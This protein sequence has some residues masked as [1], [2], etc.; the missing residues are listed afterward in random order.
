MSHLVRIILVILCVLLILPSGGTARAQETAD[1]IVTTI[2]FQPFQHGYML[3]REDEDKITVV[4]AD[5]ATKTGAPCQEVYRDTWD[6]REYTIPAPPPGLLV[7]VRGF[8]WLYKADLQLARR[9]GYATAEETGRTAEVRTSSADG[10]LVT[11]VTP[12]EPLPG[13]PASLRLAG[14]DEPGLTYCFPRRSENRDAINTWVARQLF[15]HG[16]MVWR[17]DMPDRVEIW[18]YDTQLAP[19]ISCGDT[20]ADTWKPG[21]YLTYGELA[22][23]GKRLPSRGFGNAWLEHEYIRRSLGYPVSDEQGGFAEL[24]Y[25]PFQHPTRGHLL[26]RNMTA[27]LADGQAWTSRVTI[28]N[29]ATP[30]SDRILSTACERILIPHQARWAPPFRHPARG[31]RLTVPEAKVEG[32]ARWSPAAAAS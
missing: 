3:W 8:G 4:Y 23:P 11:E 20:L 31:R 32:A 25:E 7:P 5:I 10:T 28:P 12:W 26:I 30:A 18:H 27:H 29:A 21:M 16:A 15:E 19:E 1:P 14:S 2:A 9:L 13:Q 6:D 17:Q 22:V 24:T